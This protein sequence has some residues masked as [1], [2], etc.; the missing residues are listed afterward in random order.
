M[1]YLG[2]SRDFVRNDDGS[3][4][5]GPSYDFRASTL[6]TRPPVKHNR[7]SRFNDVV[8][9]PEDYFDEL[10]D[11]PL[12]N[13]PIIDTTF[14]KIAAAGWKIHFEIGIHQVMH[15]GTRQCIQLTFYNP[16]E[17]NQRMRFKYWT[18][19]VF[20]NPGAVTIPQI[21]AYIKTKEMK[22]KFT[23]AYRGSNIIK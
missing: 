3:I 18:A 10:R 13:L 14:G 11:K 17:V 16:L 5:Q 6:P 15:Q 4:Y 8:L 9:M 19:V 12:Q 7:Y 20:P 2:N 21:V 22:P 1:V 23:N